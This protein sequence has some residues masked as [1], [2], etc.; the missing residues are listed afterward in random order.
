MV[1]DPCPLCRVSALLVRLFEPR[2]PRTA[3]GPPTCLERQLSGTSDTQSW[4][5]LRVTS[6]EKKKIASKPLSKSSIR[7]QAV[8]QHH[9]CRKKKTCSAPLSGVGGRLGEVGGGNEERIMCNTT[10]ALLHGSGSL[11]PVMIVHTSKRTL[12]KLRWLLV[13]RSLPAIKHR[14]RQPTAGVD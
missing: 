1:V 10:L 5:L 8:D 6:L 2:D 7:L 4:L 9:P 13:L 11:C 12:G 14:P 3:L